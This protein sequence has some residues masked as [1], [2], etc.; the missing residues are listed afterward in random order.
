MGGNTD[1]NFLRELVLEQQQ[2]VSYEPKIRM[3]RSG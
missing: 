3:P 2:F 1:T